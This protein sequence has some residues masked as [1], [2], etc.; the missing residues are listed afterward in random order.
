ML[1]FDRN[2][3]QALSV[4]W[5]SHAVYRHRHGASRQNDCESCVCRITQQV[6]D[7]WSRD[8]RWG[9][10]E[11]EFSRR[12]RNEFFRSCSFWKTIRKAVFDSMSF[13][14]RESLSSAEGIDL[15]FICR[16]E[17]TSAF[18]S[19]KCQLEFPIVNMRRQIIILNVANVK[20]SRKP[21]LPL[22]TLESVGLRGN[23]FSWSCTEVMPNGRPNLLLKLRLHK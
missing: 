17:L 13:R 15:N 6:V 10:C 5:T 19:S 22:S 23:W 12:G 21:F 14:Q 2:P 18:F 3:N 11:F 1:H 8:W 20:W 4:R 9:N 16:V 7:D